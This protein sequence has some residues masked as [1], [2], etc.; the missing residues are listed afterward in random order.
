MAFAIPDEIF[1]IFGIVHPLHATDMQ[2][3]SKTKK[4]CQN[5][6]KTHTH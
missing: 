4:I 2:Y 1:L 6:G 3:Q 5:S